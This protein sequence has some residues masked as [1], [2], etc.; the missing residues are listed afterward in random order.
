MRPVLVTLLILASLWTLPGEAVAQSR[1]RTGRTLEPAREEERE[2]APESP[3]GRTSSSWFLQGTMGSVGGGDL[4]HARTVDD[5]V[6]PWLTTG[7]GSF[8]SSRF[9]TSI[10]RNFGLGFAV[11]RSVGSRTR[12]RFDVESATLDLAAEA[13]VGQGGGVFRYDSVD[14]LAVGLG[15]QFALAS[16]DVAP[17][18]ALGVA[19]VG[20][21]PDRSRALDQTRF[22]LSFLLGWA[23]ELGEGYAVVIEGRATRTGFEDQGFLPETR[24][25][26]NPEIEIEWQ[27]HVTLL[28]IKVGI[29][30]N[31]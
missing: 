27:E 22:G 26:F 21:S 25:G 9:S 17:Y 30:K 8:Q 12:L 11:L 31:I 7:G 19:L 15:L 23:R 24:L 1:S 6:V 16:S 10:D 2:K 14:I 28:G 5:V 18:A 13:L 3:E 29:R 4:F 20:Y